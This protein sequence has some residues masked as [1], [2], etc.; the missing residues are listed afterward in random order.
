[1][2]LMTLAAFVKRNYRPA[3]RWD[4]ARIL[5]WLE[6]F[7]EDRR[8]AHVTDDCGRL[9]GIALARKLPDLAEA[10]DFYAHDEAAPHVFVDLVIAKKPG[11]LRVLWAA[12]VHRFGAP[13]RVAWKRHKYD[14][15]Y[16]HDFS[17]V[18][19]HL[20]LSET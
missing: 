20:T 5:L 10:G 7:R 14:M 8:L 19:K 6:W 2:N 13:V 17:L 9:V 11:V 12:M 1:M 4:G 15:T 3:R 18:T 16:A